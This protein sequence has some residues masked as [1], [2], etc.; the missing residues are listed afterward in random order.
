MAEG[1]GNGDRDVHLDKLCI[2]SGQIS[3]FWILH[4]NDRKPQYN[5]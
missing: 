3:S 4:E 5:C 2:H 1:Q